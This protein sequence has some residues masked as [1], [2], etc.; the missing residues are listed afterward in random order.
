MV[1]HIRHNYTS[2]DKLLRQ[3]S[4]NEARH[5]VEKETLEKIIEWRGGEDMT[6]EN[7][8]GDAADDLLKEVIVISDEE[9]TESDADDIHPVH[10]EQI[11]VEEL[12]SSWYE[13]DYTRALSPIA[14]SHREPVQPYPR[15]VR[16]HRPSDAQIAQRT[17]TRY[18]VWEQARRDYQSRLAQNTTVLER[19]YKPEPA[20]HS[21][22]LVPLDP[23][24]HPRAPIFHTETLPPRTT[25][26]EYEVRLSPVLDSIP[27]GRVTQTFGWNNT[28]QPLPPRQP[29]PPKFIRDAHGVLFERV[30]PQV[31]ELRPQPPQ[32]YYQNEVPTMTGALVRARPASPQESAQPAPRY[33]G[34]PEPSDGIVLP[35]VEGSDGSYLP[36]RT[37]RNPFDRQAESREA[38]IVRQERTSRDVAYIDLTSSSSQTPKRR[39]LE[40]VPPPS[41]RL[42]G[43][44]SPGRPVERYYLPQHQR[45]THVEPR[46]IEHGELHYSPQH[47]QSQAISVRDDPYAARQP[48]Y[49][50]REASRPVTRVYEP[51]PYNRELQ[52]ATVAQSHHRPQNYSAVTRNHME[53]T[54]PAG[55]INTQPPLYAGRVFEPVV[56]SHKYDSRVDREHFRPVREHVQPRVQETRVRY[57]YE[58]GTEV[59]EPL[60]SLPPQRVLEYERSGAPVRAYAR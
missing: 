24:A 33:Q 21:R 3:I 18:A 58:D 2:Y 40:E 8:R 41:G 38:N 31:R 51:M 16:I 50:T 23:P 44:G 25:R 27:L 32:R 47:H 56:E 35:S 10:H 12:P 19:V 34:N 52:A 59:R 49:E 5:Q 43:E 6:V 30:E 4:Y 53:T 1:A 55:N 11:R 26:V 17:Q 14:Q 37:R 13:R 42:A 54:L 57:V 48:V 36:P 39:R 45:T 60:Q 9:E 46:R 22:I 7:T 15:P 20:A 28:L 29:T